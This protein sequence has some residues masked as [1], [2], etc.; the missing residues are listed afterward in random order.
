M[1]TR[2]NWPAVVVITA[3]LSG[4]SCGE[5]KAYINDVAVAGGPRATLL[6]VDDQPVKRA[7]SRY[8]TVVPFAVITPGPHTLR[9]R[10]EAD[11]GGASEETLLVSA[12]VAAGKRYRFESR[13]RALQLIEDRAER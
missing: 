9:V 10:L 8:V 3:A 7:A 11:K 1:A 13:G 5:P 4:L 6:A 12:T 2:S